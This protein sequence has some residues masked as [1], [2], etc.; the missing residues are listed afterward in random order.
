VID[1]RNTAFA[2]ILGAPFHTSAF[3]RKHFVGHKK[4]QHLQQ[5][6]SVFPEVKETKNRY[7]IFMNELLRKKASSLFQPFMGWATSYFVVAPGAADFKKRWTLQGFAEVCQALIDQYQLPIFF[8]GDGK[9]KD[10]SDAIIAKLSKG[11]VNLCEKVSLIEAVWVIRNS[12]LVLCNDSA[13]MHLASYF[14]IPVV[15]LFGPTDPQKYGPW[16]DD[17]C[18]VQTQQFSLDGEG[19][20]SGIDAKEVLAKAKSILNN[21]KTKL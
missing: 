14:D 17:G 6:K 9:D 2:H 12:R 15:A 13:V 20:M 18:F 5:L 3:T 7:A 8:I 21:G 11:A 19:L 16:G 10:Y 4:G 1:L